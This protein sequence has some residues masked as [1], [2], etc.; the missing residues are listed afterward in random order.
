MTDAESRQLPPGLYQITWDDGG[1]SLA[2]V[3]ICPNGQ[4]WLAPA[5]WVRPTTDQSHWASV[6]TAAFIVAFTT[7]HDSRPIQ[8]IQDVTDAAQG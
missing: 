2:A 4:R 5:N 1:I 7:E 8:P 6:A 3:G